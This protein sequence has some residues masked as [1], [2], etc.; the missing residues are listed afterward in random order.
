MYGLL[1]VL[2]LILIFWYV[3]S[4]PKEGLQVTD[5]T[6][7]VA[8]AT[9]TQTAVAAHSSLPL[10]A[11]TMA[12]GGVELVA[13]RE[14][15]AYYSGLSNDVCSQACDPCVGDMSFA[16]NDFGAPGADFN[17]YLTSQGVD[18]SVIANHAEFIKDRQK[19]GNVTG[20]TYSPDS[21]DS[22]DPTPWIGI[23]GRPQ[24][25]PYGNPDQVADVDRSL[26]ADKQKLTWS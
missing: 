3:M 6:P 5:P 16:V 11:S 10:T 9:A 21:H 26:Y 4:R 20:R 2:V 19:F 18:S 25:V 24:N 12:P 8:V 14:N 23:R 13:Q 7:A 1:V 22:Y 15:S 17:D